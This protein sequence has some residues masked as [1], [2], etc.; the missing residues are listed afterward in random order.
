MPA[1]NSRQYEYS[2][3]TCVINGHVVEGFQGI[4]FTSALEKEHL[5]GKGSEPMSIQ[6][7]K[8]SYKGKLECT[9]SELQALQA[10]APQGDITHI[11]NIT[12]Q[13][14]FGNPSNGTASK[15]YEL[16]G[17]EFTESTMGMMSGD[18]A[19]KVSLPFIFLKQVPR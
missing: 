4:E 8:K 5:H 17:L 6:H 18:K 12:A 19:M 13:V 16:Q 11:R 3:I 1:F 15:T 7:G 9:Q 14:I 2:D 10:V